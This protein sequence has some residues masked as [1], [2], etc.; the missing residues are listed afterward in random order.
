MKYLE[1]LP[2]YQDFVGSAQ[3]DDPS[4]GTWLA[5]W[6]SRQILMIKETDLTHA[7]IPATT[8]KAI[9]VQPSV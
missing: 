5:K 9:H 2:V 8:K 7:V 3:L 1:M 6:R 4:V